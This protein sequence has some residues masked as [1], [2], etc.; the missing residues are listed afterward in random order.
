MLALGG[1]LFLVAP[2][3]TGELVRAF[4]DVGMGGAL[5]GRSRA[6]RLTFAFL[7]VQLISWT[8]NP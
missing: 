8:P 2:L 1:V 4:E 6:I 3:G 7:S 5:V